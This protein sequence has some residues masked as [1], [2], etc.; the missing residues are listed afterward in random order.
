MKLR[1]PSTSLSFKLF[2]AVTLVQA[3]LVALITA[4]GI[5]VMT[6]EFITRTEQRVAEDRHLLDAAVAPV[7]AMGG[8]EPV[9]SLLEHLRSDRGLTYLVMCDPAGK[10]LAA[11]GWDAQQPL[12]EISKSLRDAAVRESGEF[13]AETAIGNGPRRLGTL[14]FGVSTGFLKEARDTLVQ[15]A[16]VIGGIALLVSLVLIGMVSYWL[17]RNLQR[18]TE[19]SERVA[20]GDLEVQLPVESEDEVGR[21]VHAFNLMAE[22][23][24]SRIRALTESEAKFHAIADYSYDAELWFNPQGRIIWV[25]PRIYDLTGYTVEE[26]LATASFP[27]PLLAPEDASMTMKQ[28]RR[29]IKGGTG[30][31]FEFRVRR[32][33]GSILWAAADWRPIFDVDG[34]NM[35]IRISVRDV[36][37]RRE[38]EQRLAAT[39]AELRNAQS[40][41]HAY[42]ERAQDEHA[43]LS[44]LLAAMDFGIL[45][46]SNDNRIVY[47]NPAFNR[48][49]MIPPGSSLVGMPPSRALEKSDGV[50]VR[51][52]EQLRYVLALPAEGGTPGTYEVQFADGRLVNQQCHRVEDVFGRPVGHIWI[53]EDVTL[54]RQTAEQL[55]YLAERDPLTG[56]Y[57]RHRFNEELGRLIAEAERTGARLALLFFDLD[58]FKYINDTFGHRAGDAMLIR[59]AGEVA[60]QVR[61]NEILSRLGGDE[62]AI[63]VP[64]AT[65]DM[66]AAVA[67]RLT[68][69]IAGMQLSFE[70]QSL[71][72]TSSLGIAI[73]PDHAANA[74]ELI[75][76]A[77]AAMYQAKEAG[78]NIWRTYRPDLDTSRQMLT[79]ITWNERIAHAL[80]NDLM[81]LYFQGVFTAA[82]CTLTHLEVLL[83]MRDKDEPGR[84]YMPGQFVPVAERSGRI[85]DIDRWV[86]RRT[87]EVL[88]AT[89]DVPAL[90][91]NISGRSFDEPTLPRYIADELKRCQVDPGRLLVELTE[92]SAVSDLYDARRFID[93]LRQTGCHVCLDD[94]GTGFSS[95]AYLKHLNVD[96]VKIDGL[97]IRELASQ[98]DNQVFVQAIVSVA[99]G[100]RKTTIAECVEDQQALNMLRGYGVDS[101]QGYFLGHPDP[102]YRVASRR[103]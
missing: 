86:I 54:E 27:R 79:T 61:R 65:D 8:P 72:L 71:R 101:V 57:N 34:R 98:H 102:D 47:S 68:R 13:H 24:R 10:L 100:L 95:F 25:N 18:L 64:D 103:R 56:L 81:Q 9:R 66:L 46:V 43:R 88:A 91:V 50:L 80:E 63:L 1:A 41:Q 87:V 89:P 69:A 38:A 11:A 22:A 6:D 26:V 59:V 62:F 60:Q 37:K 32:K 75:A 19:A 74:E 39:V 58:E 97:F 35:G 85:L 77:D 52:Q 14:R 30:Q 20:A 21:L 49:W 17:T 84:L 51:P 53:Y 70:G 7:L 93:A 40:V 55:T 31:D 82:D 96:A 67:E 15:K 16:L 33:D 99:R 45:F 90:A 2:L 83:R 29:A 12:P 36:T 23:V 3:L 42:L 92:T 73:Y 94:F 48:I 4:I 5:E 44:A 78:K 28:I 76:H